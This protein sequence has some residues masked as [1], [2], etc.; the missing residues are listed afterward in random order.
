MSSNY[1]SYW[2]NWIIK[3]NHEI[4]ISKEDYII[5]MVVANQHSNN[6]FNEIIPCNSK[7]KLFSFFKYYALPSITLSM[8]YGI[9]YEEVTLEVLTRDE[10]YYLIDNKL[11]YSDELKIKWKKFYNRFY[12]SFHELEKEEEFIDKL[13]GILRDIVLTCDYRDGVLIEMEAYQSPKIYLMSLLKEHNDCDLVDHLE[14]RLNLKKE[15]IDELINNIDSNEF[16]LKKL[17]DYIKNNYGL[18]V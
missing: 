3:E 6:I 2:R 8:F 10:V 18:L 1:I 9:R 13:R 7:E 4:E 17:K 16:M 12:N 15:E 5:T 11:E 14:D